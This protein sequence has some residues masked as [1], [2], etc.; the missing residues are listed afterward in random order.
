MAIN[1]GSVRKA[2]GEGG[3]G[4]E[5]GDLQHAGE[6]ARMLKTL[7]ANID[8]MVY[9]C[10]HDAQWTMEFVSDGCEVLTGYDPEELL[11][12]G[13]ISYE[14]ITHPEDRARVRA[15]I[16]AALAEQRRFDIE[17]RILHRSGAERWVWERG[18]GLVGP[19]G[20]VLAL[21]GIVQDIS[22]R[23]ATWRALRDAERRYRSLFDNAIE[24]IFRTSPDGRYLDANPALA[25]IYGF[26]STAELIDSMSDIGAQLYVERSQRAAFI[27]AIR[28]DGSLSGFESQVR[29]RDGKLIWISENARA[30]RD[31]GG[32]LVCYEG[33]VEDVTELREYKERIERQARTDELT[34]LANRLQLRE[35]L[36]DTV[37]A[38][39]GTTRFA[40]VFV[41]LDR[42]KFVND[43]LGLS[44][45]FRLC[46][47]KRSKK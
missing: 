37:R 1:V 23:Q 4:G 15:A 45:E 13:R 38:A 36:E 10:L 27:A 29:R 2:A 31:E 9:R 34:G 25:R 46:V 16:D 47:I 30:V 44:I 20:G 39:G 3:E 11:F 28:R 42:F 8:G 24:G 22:A 18:S 21:E 19:E 12:N 17:Y 33:T 35:R 32:R 5:G 43:S 14:E 7:I 6:T 26:D 40:L 41:D